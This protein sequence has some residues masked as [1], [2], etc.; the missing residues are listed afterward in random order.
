[1]NCRDLRTLKIDPD[2]CHRLAPLL[3]RSVLRVAESGVSS[4]EE[5]R[6]LRKAL[7]DGVLIGE[8]LMRSS[9]HAARLRALVEAGGA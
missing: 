1:V 7:Y 3:P 9:D 5:V 4:T 6:A 8:A 2:R